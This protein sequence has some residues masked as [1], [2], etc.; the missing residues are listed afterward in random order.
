MTE[1]FQKIADKT[2]T[3]GPPLTIG[4]F[5]KLKSN[6]IR[7]TCDSEEEANRL[8]E[9]DWSKAFEGLEVRQP[10]FGV[11]FNGVPIEEINPCTDNLDNIAKEIGDRNGLKVVKLRTLRAPSKLN[12]MAR[13]NSY[14]VLTHDAEAADKLLKKGIFLNCRLFNTEK[15]TPQYQL[16]QCYKCQRY[17]HKA[18]HCRGKEKCAKCGDDHATKDCQTDAGK[19]ANCG[20]DHPAWHPDCPRRIEESERLNELKFKAKN[21]YYN[22]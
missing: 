12:P 21:A 3:S 5:R 20:D 10:K 6:D 8:R 9:I 4:G 11:V 7:F 1:R 15:Y 2:A 17:G 14:V 19:C 16:T 13:N 22:E 18:G